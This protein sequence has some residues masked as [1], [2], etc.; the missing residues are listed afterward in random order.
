MST[1]AVGRKPNML[2]KGKKGSYCM[3]SQ[4]YTRLFQMLLGFS[5][6]MSLGT[7]K[8]CLPAKWDGA[9]STVTAQL[10]QFSRK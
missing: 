9:V 2:T 5:Q 8:S 7:S 10:H 4:V 3:L 6:R 1:C